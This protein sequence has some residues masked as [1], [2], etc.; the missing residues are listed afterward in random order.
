MIESQI[1]PRLMDAHPG[2][3]LQTSDNPVAS[4]Q[5]TEAELEAFSTI[6]LSN[7]PEESLSHVK[8]II[9]QGVSLESI[10]LDLITPAARWLGRQWEED[11]MDFTAVT[12]GLMRMHQI[13]RNLGYVNTQ[14]PQS[15]SEVKRILLACAPGSMHILGLAIVA[16]FFRSNGWQV[17]VDISSTETTLAQA[18]KREWFDMI[19]L[20]VGLVEQLHELPHLISEL[21]SQALNPSTLVILGGP[22]ALLSSDIAKKSGAD[23]VATQADKAVELANGL[24]KAQ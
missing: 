13:T 1:I 11:K 2:Q 3:G 23:G 19:G 22:A 24:L 18:L 10:F 12:H 15:G 8:N 6:C 21:K 7:D 17:V 16:E 14:S 9:A 4:R 20:S 5:F